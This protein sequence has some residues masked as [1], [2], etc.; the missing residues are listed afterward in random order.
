MSL[1]YVYRPCR[2]LAPFGARIYVPLT[3]NFHPELLPLL[4]GG[5]AHHLLAPTQTRSRP[6]SPKRT[7]GP[8]SSWSPGATAMSSTNRSTWA[9]CSV[10]ARLLVDIMSSL[11]FLTSPRNV[12]LTPRSTGE[13][14][15]LVRSSTLV[16]CSRVASVFRCTRESFAGQSCGFHV[17]FERF[18]IHDGMC[19][20]EAPIWPCVGACWRD[21]VK[22]SVWFKSHHTDKLH[23]RPSGEQREAVPRCISMDE[24]DAL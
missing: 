22:I 10:V 7:A 11:A 3:A 17:Y 20:F 21:Q 1:P 16:P 4:V 12:L 23:T 9:L 8:E 18:R 5:A 6:C 14:Q 19:G 24:N 2:E 13:K 15:P